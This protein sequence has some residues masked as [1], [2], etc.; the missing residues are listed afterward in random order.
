MVNEFKKTSYSRSKLL[1]PLDYTI[2]AGIR[3]SYRAII[4]QDSN[5]LA[6]AEALQNSMSS[7]QKSD[8]NKLINVAKE[9]VTGIQKLA[10]SCDKG[11]LNEFN[12]QVAEFAKRLTDL[13]TEVKFLCKTDKTL[14]KSINLITAAGQNVLYTSRALIND[15][16]NEILRHQLNTG[17][18]LMVQQLK[19]LVIQ[20]QKALQIQTPTDFSPVIPL[21]EYDEGSSKATASEDNAT[22]KPPSRPVSMDNTS[23]NNNNKSNSSSGDAAIQI[24]DILKTELPW[25][26]HKWESKTSKPQQLDIL[27]KLVD[28]LNFNAS[29][30]VLIKPNTATTIPV[31]PAAAGSNAVGR[32]I[33]VRKLDLPAISNTKIT[34]PPASAR[35]LSTRELPT[36][37]PAATSSPAES[38]RGKPRSSTTNVSSLSSSA[39][40]LLTHQV[41]KRSVTANVNKEEITNHSN[42]SQN[43]DNNSKTGSD[44]KT[45]AV[46]I[47]KRNSILV[48]L[49]GN[50]ALSQ[51]LL[52]EEELEDDERAISEIM[53]VRKFSEMRSVTFGNFR[54]IMNSSNSPT[55][56]QVQ[57]TSANRIISI[58]AK[59]KS[60]ANLP[61]P[62]TAGKTQSHRIA[63][64]TPRKPI[65]AF[66]S[67]R[68][69]VEKAISNLMAK[70][71]VYIVDKAGMLS[72]NYRNGPRKDS[73]IEEPISLTNLT[74]TVRTELKKLMTTIVA[75]DLTFVKEEKVM[76]DVVMAKTK[77]SKFCAGLVDDVLVYAFRTGL[78]GFV[79]RSLQGFLETQFKE[80]QNLTGMISL[81]LSALEPKDGQ[82]KEKE[83]E[84]SS[85]NVLGHYNKDKKLE[86]LQLMIAVDCFIEELSKFLMMVETWRYI[87]TLS[88]DLPRR[89]SSSASSSSSSDSSSNATSS[90]SSPIS[91]S[92]AAGSGIGAPSTDSSLPPSSSS[93]T[94]TT[95]E[96]GSGS[97]TTTT[98]GTTTNP[99]EKHVNLY[100]ESMTAVKSENLVASFNC[101]VRILTDENS[102]F[103]TKFCDTF[104]C[105]LVTF[106]T[107]REFFEKLKE[108]FFIPKSFL[109]NS[110]KKKVSKVL[111]LIDDETKNLIELRVL[112][113]L[114]YWIKNYFVETFLSEDPTLIYEIIQFLK[115]EEDNNT[116]INSNNSN[117]AGT[118]ELIKSSS[119]NNNRHLEMCNAI[120]KELQDQM[121]K[122]DDIEN[123]SKKHFTLS[124]S[125]FSK[126]HPSSSSSSHPHPPKEDSSNPSSS[127]SSS[128]TTK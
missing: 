15:T 8:M 39:T 117:P 44:Q 68:N 124:L 29:G 73:T 79:I 99:K 12:Q 128:T 13:T 46:R 19:D 1:H 24:I 63:N 97:T 53:R 105:T 112:Q 54:E 93:S 45:N 57:P 121:S 82:P 74:S 48:G 23:A 11:K 109:T 114:Q 70:A 52:S 106:T 16:S 14:V 76:M 123:I 34:T 61:I 30:G 64:S 113:T 20:S 58:H 43:K 35:T 71:G 120:E 91:P 47:I 87:N 2:E 32:S 95:P 98:I 3:K 7:I 80:I 107:P 77:S 31:G 75:E 56:T 36:I 103:D 101:L 38:P 94:T 118:S 28:T 10:S 127:S 100:E 126:E 59:T 67:S 111:S 102:E 89:S 72:I 50:D 81:M 41:S 116:I 90:R 88:L 25:F 83:K 27:K 42:A 108:R 22:N 18:T 66:E 110:K 115:L 51:G 85:N 125:Y 26:A 92:R 40:N 55:L 119:S 65:P 122:L 84:S 60:I 6:A 4:E 5:L 86:K 49:T 37:K 9:V 21:S 62:S 33:S 96:S 78:K 69:A 104:C 17:I